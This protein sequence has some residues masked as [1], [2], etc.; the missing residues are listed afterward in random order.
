MVKLTLT[1][2]AVKKIRGT[3]DAKICVE[4]LESNWQQLQAAFEAAEDEQDGL[5]EHFNAAIDGLGD[6]LFG[7]DQNDFKSKMDGLNEV[8]EEAF[9]EALKQSGLIDDLS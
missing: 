4:I 2:E 9:I 6:A 3:K 7:G 8:E 1:K 5:I